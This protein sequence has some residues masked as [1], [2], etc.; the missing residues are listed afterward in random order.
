MLRL[1]GERHRELELPVL[2]VAHAG[3]ASVFGAMA[4]AD[5]LE[6]GARRLAQFGFGPR[7]APEPERMA[8]VGLHRQRDVIQRGEMRKQAT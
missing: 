2:A 3:D 7:R 6:R 5:A 4:D 1:G 8:G